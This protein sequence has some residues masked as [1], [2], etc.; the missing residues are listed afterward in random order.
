MKKRMSHICV[1]IDGAL[2]SE[3]VEGF[4]S[5]DD[6]ELSDTEVRSVLNYFKNQDFKY[7]VGDVCDHLSPEGRCLGHEYTEVSGSAEETTF[8]TGVKQTIPSHLLR[9]RAIAAR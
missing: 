8:P 2:R 9:T 4:I 1:S 3:S 6:R 7:F 5:H